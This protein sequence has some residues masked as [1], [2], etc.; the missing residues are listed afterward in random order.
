MLSLKKRKYILGLYFFCQ[1]CLYCNKDCSYRS[2]K[3][4]KLRKNLLPENKKG[5][6]RKCYSR[7]FQSNNS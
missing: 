2:C 6:K 4:N 7:T 5:E 1:E 3:C